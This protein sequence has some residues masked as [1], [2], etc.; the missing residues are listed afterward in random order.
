MK[1]LQIANKAIYPPDGGN[2]AI[3]SLSKGYLMNGYQVHLLNMETEKHY[4]KQDI[5]PDKYKKNLTITGVSIKT[6]ISFVKLLLNLLFSNDAYI[7]T[8]FYSKEFQIKL[9]EIIS[10]SEFDFIQ[11]EG[12]YALQ[13]IND[14]RKI[15]KGKIVYRSHNIEYKIWNR[16]ANNSKNLFKKW[17]FKNL[18]KRLRNLEI[19]LLNQYDIILPISAIDAK[20]YELLGNNKPLF[21][22]PYGME[23]DN[24]S[25]NRNTLTK[26][27][28]NYIGALDWIPNQQGILWFISE[29]LPTI[30][31][32]FPD[33][34]F[35]I[36]G[37]NAPDWF[38]N[39]LNHPNIDY[40]GEI[41]SINEFYS[42]PGPFIVPLFSGSG[43]R[44]KIIEAMAYKKAIV[45]TSIGSEGINSINNINILISDN[46]ISF[47]YSLIELLSNLN[48]QKQI[49]DNAFKFVKENYDFSNIAKQV[50]N[51]IA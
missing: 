10:N 35:K 36:A 41:A 15:Y 47:A 1:I 34:K 50:L 23:I 22:T 27:S 40:L 5:I 21:I 42:L 16:N 30:A 2:L 33:I 44:V 9:K 46:K 32:K 45:T 19:K 25:A 20:E 4:N 39:K 51:F 29:C 17:Y 26:Q 24:I 8:R 12:L 37:R 28:I 31:N 49:G 11:L 43:M 6:S 18:A 48:L 38:I 7:A 14:I 13:Y 3:L